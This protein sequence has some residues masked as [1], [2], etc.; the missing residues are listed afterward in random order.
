MS[1]IICSPLS[2][3]RNTW[4]KPSR[5][6]IEII[7]KILFNHGVIEGM[8]KKDKAAGQDDDNETG[9]KEKKT[10]DY[11]QKLFTYYCLS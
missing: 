5:E 6:W 4:S 2:L 11:N 7:L 9:S 1:F 3:D 10:E 8:K